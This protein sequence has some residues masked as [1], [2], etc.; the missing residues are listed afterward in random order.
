MQC[1]KKGNTP[2][3]HTKIMDLWD[4]SFFLVFWICQISIMN[5]YLFYSG[6]KEDW[7]PHLRQKKGVFFFH[8]WGMLCSISLKWYFKKD[9]LLFSF[10]LAHAPSDNLTSVCTDVVDNSPRT[11]VPFI[12][13]NN[14]CLDTVISFY[15]VGGYSYQLPEG[16]ML[17]LYLLDMQ[18]FK[19]IS[20]PYCFPSFHR[21]IHHFSLML[22]QGSCIIILCYHNYW[23]GCSFSL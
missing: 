12:L 23:N 20:I 15:D 7:S 13:C 18:W 21:M 17:S 16:D 2:R 1:H 5:R 4:L 22:V 3:F 8:Y 9:G 14:W 19:N 6:E 10:F 11:M